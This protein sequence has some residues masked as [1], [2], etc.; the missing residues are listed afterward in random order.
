MGVNV[1]TADECRVLDPFLSS[2]E[3]IFTQAGA[4]MLVHAAAL[5]DDL[6]DAMIEHDDGAVY[7]FRRRISAV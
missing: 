1:V 3:R 2:F 7:E 6:L 4:L 5:K